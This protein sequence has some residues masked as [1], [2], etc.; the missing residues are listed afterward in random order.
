MP[1]LAIRWDSGRLTLAMHF[2]AHIQISSQV[3]FGS[4]PPVLPP[5]CYLFEA[6]SATFIPRLVL[7]WIRK[8]IFHS[9]IMRDFSLLR[10]L[11]SHDYQ[12]RQW[13]SLVW[14]IVPFSHVAV[15][16]HLF[17]FSHH[18]SRMSLNFHTLV[19]RQCSCRGHCAS[20]RINLLTFVGSNSRQTVHSDE[21]R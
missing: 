5:H 21:S 4:C 9:Q 11:H 6:L 18:E 10:L 20:Q 19:P 17:P 16:P 1:S 8:W 15:Q 7:T 13:S 2:S 3:H 14:E 12:S